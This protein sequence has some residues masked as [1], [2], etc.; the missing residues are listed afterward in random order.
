MFSDLGVTKVAASE[1]S[2]ATTIARRAITL[3]WHGNQR[4]SFGLDAALTGPLYITGR[5]LAPVP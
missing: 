3:I 5:Y 4:V 2:G 1:G